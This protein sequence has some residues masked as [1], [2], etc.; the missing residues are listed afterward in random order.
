MT[1]SASTQTAAEEADARLESPYLQ[2]GEEGQQGVHPAARV[3][4]GLVDVYVQ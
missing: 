4:H 3:Q 2:T 1:A